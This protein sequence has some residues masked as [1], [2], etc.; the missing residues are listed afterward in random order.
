MVVPH[1]RDVFSLCSNLNDFN[2]FPVVLPL[3]IQD[4]LV[5]FGLHCPNNYEL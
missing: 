5:K 2:L 4:I 1:V 3:F